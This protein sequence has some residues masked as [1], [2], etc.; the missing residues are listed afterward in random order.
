MAL[1]GSSMLASTQSVV[2]VPIDIHLLESATPTSGVT[3][4][5]FIISLYMM[6]QCLRYDYDQIRAVYIYRNYNITEIPANAFR[7]APYLKV[8]WHPTQ[9]NIMYTFI[10]DITPLR[11]FA[12]Q[13]FLQ[14]IEYLLD[15]SNKNVAFYLDRI[16]RS[17]DYPISIWGNILPVRYGNIG[18][19]TVKPSSR[20]P[21]KRTSGLIKR[22]LGFI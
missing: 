15:R 11:Q 3:T 4:L 19:L 6:E 2:S 8:T 5:G 7:G 20:W 21:M 12:L 16:S 1:E 22:G 14:N 9:N 10:K 18:I 17:R 13:L